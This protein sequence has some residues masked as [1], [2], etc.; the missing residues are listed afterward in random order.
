MAIPGL[1][2]SAISDTKKADLIREFIADFYELPISKLIS[3]SR[4]RHIVNARQLCAMLIYQFTKL[5]LKYIG[6]FLGGKDHATI[7][8]SVKEQSRIAGNSENKRLE[9]DTLISTLKKRFSHMQI[10]WLEA[11]EVEIEPLPQIKRFH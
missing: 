7:L 8:H 6:N 5:P 3:K 10:D 4:E 11:R 9:I 1:R 2:L